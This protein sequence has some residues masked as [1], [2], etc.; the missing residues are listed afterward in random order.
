MMCFLLLFTN[1]TFHFY[2]SLTSVT[3]L[4]WWHTNG[5]AVG[6]GDSASWRAAES[7][8][9]TTIED[10]LNLFWH[11]CWPAASAWDDCLGISSSVC[12]WCHA[13]F[14]AAAA[15]TAS[16]ALLFCWIYHCFNA[17]YRNFIAMTSVSIL[18]KQ[19]ELTLTQMLAQVLNRICHPENTFNRIVVLRLPGELLL[20]FLLYYNLMK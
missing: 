4:Y 8:R 14:W 3:V 9:R 10:L 6:T 18:I 1:Y 12:R 5:D 13:T 19:C 17:S 16:G 11:C 15:P 2:V 20:L 7:A